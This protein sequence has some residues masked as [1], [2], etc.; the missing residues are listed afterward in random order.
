MYTWFCQCSLKADFRKILDL[1][2]SFA[3][4]NS[5]ILTPET[6]TMMLSNPAK[7]KDPL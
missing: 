4:K 7:G 3:S 1:K 6:F 2:K 5:D